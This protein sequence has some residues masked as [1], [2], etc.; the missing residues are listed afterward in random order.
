MKGVGRRDGILEV[1][2][3]IFDVCCWLCFVD[4]EILLIRYIVVIVVLCDSLD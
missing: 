1:V 4:L 3:I 2:G